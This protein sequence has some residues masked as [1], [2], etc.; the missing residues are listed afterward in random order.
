MTSKKDRRICMDGAGIGVTSKLTTYGICAV[1]EVPHRREEGL[2]GSR[3]QCSRLIAE[4]N[5]PDFTETVRQR[6]RHSL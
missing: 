4:R 1:T 2:S 5:Q 6:Y 3:A